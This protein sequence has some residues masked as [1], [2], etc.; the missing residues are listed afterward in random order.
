LSLLRFGLGSALKDEGIPAPI[1]SA[2][3]E[4][5][6]AMDRTIATIQSLDADERAAR[7][8]RLQREFTAWRR[9][10]A[11]R[12]DMMLDPG[13]LV[14]GDFPQELI[15]PFIDT[16][17]D[18]VALEIFPKLPN[19]AY[20]GVVDPLDPA[21]LH[22]FVGDVYGVDQRAT[23]VIMQ[24]YNSGDLILRSYQQAGVFAL[25]AVFVLVL[26]DFRNLWDALLTLVPVAVGFA[27]TFGIMWAL[28]P[29]GD[30]IGILMQINAANIIV[31]PLM[32]GIGVDSGVH[33]IHR[34]RQDPGGRPPGMTAGTGKAITITS[35][36]TMIGFGAMM[37][38]SHRGIRSL[39]FVLTLG[40]GLTM[41]ACWMVM[42]AWLELCRRRG[43]AARAAEQ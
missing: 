25:L 36:T 7:M 23:G 20:P 33:I 30:R 13:P 5:N 41:L 3:Q 32:F 12:L 34:H 19:E 17:G 26:I 14:P 38:A 4:L 28:R 9:A 39:G 27:V 24:V 31:L 2:L 37:I 10:T 42:P 16:R 11:R 21:F 1:K 29:V 43:G 18:R 22:D 40:I 8:Q 35:L 15:A 6:D